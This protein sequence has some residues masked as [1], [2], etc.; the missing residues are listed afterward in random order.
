LLKE[1]S[2]LPIFRSV[3][4]A[5]VLCL[6]PC[7]ATI[8]ASSPTPEATAGPALGSVI[9]FN[10]LP[11]SPAMAA[12][13][14]GAHAHVV[15]VPGVQTDTLTLRAD[16][17]PA[18]AEFGLYAAALPHAPFGLGRLLSGVDVD[19]KGEAQTT[20]QALLL[21]AGGVGVNTSVTAHLVLAFRGL[22]DAGP[23]AATASPASSGQ[24]A[25]PAAFA[26]TGF[27]DDGGPLLRSPL[28]LP[29]LGVSTPGGGHG[30]A[31][32]A[33]TF[34]STCGHPNG[35]QAIRFIDFRFNVDGRAAF[36]VRLDRPAK[37]MYVYDTASGRWIGPGAPGTA[38][39]LRTSRAAL[40]LRA[41]AV[42][43]S[44]GTTG[45][46]T[47]S[48]AFAAPTRGTTFQQ[49]V[50]VTDQ[51]DQTRGWNPSGSWTVE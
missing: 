38:Q 29:N 46:V 40:F 25:G 37:R 28:A 27:A 24:V 1:L 49:S 16:H 44:L 47:W 33:S 17:L 50:R 18:F 43:G 2:V 19:D 26:T 51:R 21:G 9:A 39:V 6:F 45:T 41:S 30:R 8:A 34:T 14:P 13:L 10:L 36:W 32:F 4:T 20:V 11:A 7:A 15:I 48:I 22:E 23:C 42:A 3:G 5:L 35:W 12:C 31:L